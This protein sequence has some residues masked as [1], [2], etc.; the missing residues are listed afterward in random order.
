MLTRT[1]AWS[2]IGRSRR[3]AGNAAA[4]KTDSKKHTS[5]LPELE[6]APAVADGATGPDTGAFRPASRLKNWSVMH[7]TKAERVLLQSAAC[8]IPIDNQGHEIAVLVETKLPLVYTLS[9]LSFVVRARAQCF[10]HDVV[11][12]TRTLLLDVVPVVLCPQF[13]SLVV[14][15]VLVLLAAQNIRVLGFVAT[16]G[17]LL[18]EGL[19]S[20]GMLFFA[21]AGLREALR[22]HYRRVST[23]EDVFAALAR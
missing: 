22:C 17:R 5:V 1:M 11:A 7:L 3:D 18:P 2:S 10:L 20:V 14:V 21:L 23:A 4:T 12:A 13:T 15:F 6:D 8:R 9:A 16:V 19:C